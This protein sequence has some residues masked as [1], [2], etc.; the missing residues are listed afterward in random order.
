MDRELALTFRLSAQRDPSCWLRKRTTDAAGTGSH[1]LRPQDASNLRN[2]KRATDQQ[3]QKLAV[4]YWLIDD[5][6]LF[7]RPWWRYRPHR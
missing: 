4:H 3:S 1:V 7:A 6:H 2:H 5:R